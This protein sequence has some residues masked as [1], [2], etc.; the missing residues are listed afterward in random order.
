[1]P[2]QQGVSHVEIYHKLGALEGKVD[3]L[4][5]ALSE[6]KE[7]IDLAFQRISHLENKLA[8]VLGAVA[9]VSVVIPL[10]VTAAAPTV[11]F[12][13]APVVQETR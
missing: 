3:A 7:A 1:M 10:V 2:E 11:H 13:P 9:V 12:R 5:T 8:W 4:I 6:K